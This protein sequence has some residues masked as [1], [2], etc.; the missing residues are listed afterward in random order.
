[1]L[2]G[3]IQATDFFPPEG[4]C[5]GPQAE[6]TTFRKKRSTMLPQARKVLR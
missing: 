2:S 4:C 5:F 3:D 1:M 6:T